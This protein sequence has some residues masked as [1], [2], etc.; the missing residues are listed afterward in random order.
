MTRS[1]SA[2]IKSCLL[3]DGQEGGRG[4]GGCA[5]VLD[6]RCLLPPA[7]WRY[8]VLPPSKTVAK[9]VVEPHQHLF[10]SQLQCTLI[11]S[12]KEA[13]FST[14]ANERNPHE[15]LIDHLSLLKL[16]TP[17]PNYKMQ[18]YKSIHELV[19]KKLISQD[20]LQLPLVPCRRHSSG[21]LNSSQ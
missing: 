20:V 13:S 11:S 19:N 17:Q 5:L 3:R 14:S 21:F 4:G 15:F 12:Y 9:G 18:T 10:L 1:P 7:I 6:L 16:N 2:S 8:I